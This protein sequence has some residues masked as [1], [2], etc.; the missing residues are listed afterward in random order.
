M[1]N[2]RRLRWTGHVASMGKRRGTY[3]VLVG[4]PERRRAVR[5]L[6][7]KWEDNIKILKSIFREWDG[8]HGLDRSGSEQGQ[9]VGSWMRY[10]TSVFH[11][12]RGICWKTEYLLAA[13]EGLCSTES[14]S[15]YIL[16]VPHIDILI[17]YLNMF[18]N[19]LLRILKSVSIF[20]VCMSL[21]PEDDVNE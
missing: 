19:L 2:L 5:R 4:K 17:I 9:V 11:K 8:W 3:R 6:R 10:Q 14:I 18:Y 21:H 1:I 13:Q 12:V 15:S 20:S 7:R 16:S